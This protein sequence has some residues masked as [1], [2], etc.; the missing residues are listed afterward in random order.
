MRTL[1]ITLPLLLLAACAHSPPKSDPSSDVVPPAS[2]PASP[3]VSFASPAA[4]SPRSASQ[5]IHAAYGSRVA[6]LRA[7][8]QIDAAGLTVVGVTAT[9]IRLFTASFDGERVTAERSPFVP[10]EVSPERVLADMQLALWPLDSLRGVYAAVGQ[11]VSEPMPGLRR[12][13]RADRLIAE[14]HYATD[15]PWNGRLWFVN[16]ES[17][18]SLTI[19]TTLSN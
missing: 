3:P 18:Y 17:G 8:V 6:T 7:A 12:L 10:K 14:V 1:V 4:L 5:V 9:G 16:F 11:S 2:A 13:V 19:D 15:D